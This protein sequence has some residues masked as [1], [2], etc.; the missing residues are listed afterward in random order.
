MSDPVTPR[1]C[2]TRA[3]LREALGAPRGAQ[4]S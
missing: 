1:V 3:E 4:S 2:R